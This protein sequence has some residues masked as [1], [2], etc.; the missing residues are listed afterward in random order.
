[1]SS[2][3]YFLLGMEEIGEVI[4]IILP[5][6]LPVDLFRNLI[7][8]INTGKI[9][10]NKV[11]EMISNI[12]NNSIIKPLIEDDK[13]GEHIKNQ[14]LNKKGQKFII[15]MGQSGKILVKI[16][17]NSE[18]IKFSEATGNESLPVLPFKQEIILDAL[19]KGDFRL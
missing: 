6:P 2:N 3:R 11:L 16:I 17:A 8:G 18:Y 15:D 12:L 9:P 10:K 13:V 5:R 1:M 19:E 4:D 14:F 7:Q